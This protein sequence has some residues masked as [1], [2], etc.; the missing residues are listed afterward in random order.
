MKKKMEDTDLIET[1][2]NRGGQ[3]GKTIHYII[4]YCICLLLAIMTWL[5]VMYDKQDE[6]KEETSESACLTE[7]L[8]EFVCQI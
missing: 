4:V 1:R 2:R 8:Q 5:F 3:G 7:E 6:P